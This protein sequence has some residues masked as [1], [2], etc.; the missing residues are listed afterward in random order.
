[1]WLFTSEGVTEA[2]RL[3][4]RAR[5]LDPTFAAAYAHE[6]YTHYIN[7]MVGYSI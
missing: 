2:L 7:L 1:M 6:A 5:E 4:Q 3:F